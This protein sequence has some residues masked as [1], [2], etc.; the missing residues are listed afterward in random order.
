MA[1]SARADLAQGTVTRRRDQPIEHR[2]THDRPLDPAAM[3]AYLQQTTGNH[4]LNQLVEEREEH[5]GLEQA[6]SADP[7]DRSGLV[8]QRLDQVPAELHDPIVNALKPRFPDAK[9][10][11]ESRA[12]NA[13]GNA[14]AAGGGGQFRLWRSSPHRRVAIAPQAQKSP[15]HR[16]RLRA[17]RRP[18]LARG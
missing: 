7:Q 1:E 2:L 10:L 16:T 9:W 11:A 12:G 15:T 17:T 13:T 8:R 3:A 14:A 18:T 4:S 6:L 5:A